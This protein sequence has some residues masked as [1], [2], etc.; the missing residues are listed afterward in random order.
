MVKTGDKV[1]Y[2]GNSGYAKEFFKDFNDVYVLDKT[3]ISVLDIKYDFCLI[4]NRKTRTR[5]SEGIYVLEENI[6]KLI[7]KVKRL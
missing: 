3:T 2:I 5:S 4:G 6:K 7:S 1:K